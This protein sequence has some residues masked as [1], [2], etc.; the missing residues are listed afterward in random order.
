G[1]R[2]DDA[3]P[4]SVKSR[5]CRASTVGAAP[6]RTDL[7]HQRHHISTSFTAGLHEEGF[8][9]RLRCIVCR[10]LKPSLAVET[11]FNQV[12]KDRYCFFTSHSNLPWSRVPKRLDCFTLLA[13]IAIMPPMVVMPPVIAS[14]VVIPVWV[15]VPV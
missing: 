4:E 13:P 8:D 1:E 9:R 12:V 3:H 6:Q 14:C 2:P 7:A 5:H 11:G 15:V 10:F